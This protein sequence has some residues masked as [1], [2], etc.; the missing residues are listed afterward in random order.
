MTDKTLVGRMARLTKKST[1]LKLAKND[2]VVVV[3]YSKTVTENDGRRGGETIIEKMR[4]CM[5]RP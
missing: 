3:S 5:P 1:Q 2:Y 4:P